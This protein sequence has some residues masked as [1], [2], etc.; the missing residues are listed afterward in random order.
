MKFH[1]SK[2]VNNLVK[3]NQQSYISIE[4]ALHYIYICTRALVIKEIV[5][6]ENLVKREP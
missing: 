4:I 5:C 1:E 2:S 6:I 3:T